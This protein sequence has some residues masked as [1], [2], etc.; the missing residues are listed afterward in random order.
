MDF[1]GRFKDKNKGTLEAI[2]KHI[3]QSENRGFLY[4]FYDVNIY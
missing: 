2:I 1:D 4:S 3:K